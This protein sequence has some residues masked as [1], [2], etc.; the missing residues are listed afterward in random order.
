VRTRYPYHRR[1]CQQCNKLFDST[2]YDAKFC[3]ATCRTKAHRAQFKKQKAI[4]NANKAVE[5]LLPYCGAGDA[6]EA[7]HTLIKWLTNATHEGQF[8]IDMRK[9]YIED[10]S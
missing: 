1:E 2:R 9:S 5:A 3:C 4:D 7:M 6:L 10:K 8:R